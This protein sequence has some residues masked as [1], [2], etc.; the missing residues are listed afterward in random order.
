VARR[1]KRRGLLY[2]FLLMLGRAPPARRS[3]TS[4]TGSSTARGPDRIRGTPR[5]PGAL[6]V[7]VGLFVLPFAATAGLAARGFLDFLAGHAPVETPRHRLGWTAATVGV[8]TLA[9]L[10]L[11]PRRGIRRWTSRERDRAIARGERAATATGH[12]SARPV[13]RPASRAT[14]RSPPRSAPPPARH[15]RP[16][17]RISGATSASVAAEGGA[18]SEPRARGPRRCGARSLRRSPYSPEVAP[19]ETSTFEF[20]VAAHKPR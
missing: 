14:G 1:L 11:W 19:G 15:G 9:Y 7:D 4:P 2:V 20:H 12:G 10:G 8:A 5:R 6:P 16:G 17:R 3:S 18:E 13:P